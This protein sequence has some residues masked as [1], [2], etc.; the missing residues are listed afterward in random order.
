M[1]HR[2]LTAT[3]RELCLLLARSG[4]R[5]SSTAEVQLHSGK[6]ILPG[7][8]HVDLAR[9]AACVAMCPLYTAIVQYFCTQR[10]QWIE[11]GAG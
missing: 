3:F 6:C 2:A 11:S 7:R 1:A 9:S 5:K 8:P 10:L 4:L